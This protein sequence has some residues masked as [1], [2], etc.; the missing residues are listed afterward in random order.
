MVDYHINEGFL[1]IANQLCVPISSL[2]EQLIRNLHAGRL[3]G[4]LGHGGT[5]L[6]A[7]IEA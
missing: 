7:L 2:R 5:L 1:F 4:H 3:S 6:L